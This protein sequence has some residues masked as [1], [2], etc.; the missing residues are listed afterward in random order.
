MFSL[1]IHLDPWDRYLKGDTVSDNGPARD[2]DR[3]YS[4]VHY[5]MSPALEQDYIKNHA[6]EVCEKRGQALVCTKK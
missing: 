4:N 6:D 2:D 3:R 1:T 5:F